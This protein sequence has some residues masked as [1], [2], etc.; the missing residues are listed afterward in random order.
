MEEDWVIDIRDQCK[1]QDVAFFFKQ[2]GG[3]HPKSNG[4]RLAGRE[5]NNYP[6]LPPDR[7]QP[8]A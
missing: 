2:W 5:H 7:L 1:A 8:N 4:R 3:L 6:A